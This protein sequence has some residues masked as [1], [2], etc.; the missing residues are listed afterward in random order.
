MK[1][2]Q[3]GARIAVESRQRTQEL[4][5]MYATARNPQAAAVEY[6]TAGAY[7]A[8]RYYAQLGDADAQQR[9]DVYNRVAAHQTTADNPGLL[10][11]NIVSPLVNFI[12]RRPPDLSPRIG[13][14]DLGS[15]AWSYARVTQ[16]T[17]RRQAGRGE[18]RAGRRARCW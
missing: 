9:M 8:D 13:P 4:V 15:G 16:H 1:P 11:E 5:G 17:Q 18:D 6:R 7:I 2:L 3:E 12:E 14:T 10:P